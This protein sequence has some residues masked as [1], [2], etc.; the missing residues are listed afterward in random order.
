VQPSE[1]SRLLLRAASGDRCAPEELLPL[2]YQQ[3]R[4]AAQLVMRNE[5]PDHTL[6][7]TALVNEAYAKLVG[8]QPVAW[9]SRAHF[10]AAAA[11][12]MRQIL[13][14]HARARMT[15][16]RGGQASR[17]E[18]TDF[19]AA[20]SAPAEH[21]FALDEAISRL[22]DCDPD[23]AE[24]VRLRF[25]AGLSGDEAAASLGISPRKLDMLWA[26]ARARLK[27][28]LEA[29]ATGEIES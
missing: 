1:V 18:L 5:R 20:F 6:Q 16:K 11:R 23:A 24:V 15:D 3:L 28:D 12:A 2:V 14:D 13:V 4:A 25:F 26:R 22:D 27:R 17:V 19:A 9:T 7:A 8:G 29:S 21:I 10:Y